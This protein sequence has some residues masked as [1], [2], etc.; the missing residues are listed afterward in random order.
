MGDNSIEISMEELATALILSQKEVEKKIKK[1]KF[2]SNVK[3]GAL[4][5]GLIYY[6]G[7]NQGR[8]K[9]LAS[10]SIDIDVTDE[11]LGENIEEN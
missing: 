2:W 7:Y 5:I 3:F 1:V 9:E 4:L 10:N 6:I 11:E 8:W